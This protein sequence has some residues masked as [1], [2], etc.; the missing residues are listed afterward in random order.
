[1]SLTRDDIRLSYRLFLGRWPSEKEVERMLASQPPLDALRRMFLDSEEFR[2]TLRQKQIPPR[3]TKAPAAGPTIIHLHIPKTAGSSLS[4]LLVEDTRPGERM[5]I[6]DAETAQLL[7]LAPAQQQRL[8]LIFGHLTYG[9]GAHLPQR[10]HHVCVLRRPGPRIL[11]YYRYVRRTDHHPLYPVLTAGGMTFGGFLDF[12]AAHP[13]I[14]L[15][16][17]NGQ[18][19]RL[20]GN[21]EVDGIGRE[22]LLLRRAL[23]HLFAPDFTYGLTEHFDGFQKRLV[24]K[25]LLSAPAPIR[26]NAAPEPGQLEEELA[27]LTPAQRKTYDAYTAWDDQLYSICKTAYFARKTIKEALS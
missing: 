26:E 14:R 9:I 4:R 1:M 18:V 25:G 19:R 17:D 8:K 16:V 3:D 23:H 24:R 22:G 27:A 12:T 13:Q 2:A 7:T 21:M 6:G 5:T 11:S 20:G 15:E 10:C